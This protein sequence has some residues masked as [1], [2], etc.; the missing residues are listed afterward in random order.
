MYSTALVRMWPVG[1]RTFS[2]RCGSCTRSSWY[3]F[4][5]SFRRFLSRTLCDLRFVSGSSASSEDPGQESGGVGLEVARDIAVSAASMFDLDKCLDLDAPPTDFRRRGAAVDDGELG[6][7]FQESRQESRS[8]SEDD[9]SASAVTYCAYCSEVNEKENRE[10]GAA[11]PI[12]ADGGG[13]AGGVAQ[14][15]LDSAWRALLEPKR[16]S[17]AAMEL[18]MDDTA[19]SVAVESD[20]SWSKENCKFARE[21]PLVSRLV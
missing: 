17:E 8:S 5:R 12:T 11:G 21:Q 13:D 3:E 20:S 10:F 14:F 4:L 19:P 9:R 1:A 2:E 6:A 15:V 16:M 7:V 18:D